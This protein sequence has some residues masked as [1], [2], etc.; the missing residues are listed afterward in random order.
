MLEDLLSIT[1]WG[2][3]KSW[4]LKRVS[5]CSCNNYA[6]VG[7]SW[8]SPVVEQQSLMRAIILKVNGVAMVT[9]TATASVLHCFFRSC[10]IS[11]WGR[12]LC[13]AAMWSCL[14]RCLAD[15]YM[16]NP[17][18]ITTLTCTSVAR[19]SLKEVVGSKR[20]LGYWSITLEILCNMHIQLQHNYLLVGTCN[21]AQL[22]QQIPWL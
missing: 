11:L 8:A 13:T 6:N 15:I 20:R 2:S 19:S 9:D 10:C 17:C 18:Y 5:K 22:E 3:M 1:Y 12:F 16:Y 4:L 14:C 7:L 21:P